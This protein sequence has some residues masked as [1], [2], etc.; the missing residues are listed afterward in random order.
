LPRRWS[1]I[2]PRFDAA[3]FF[4]ARSASRSTA[5]CRAAARLAQ[6]QMLRSIFAP[7]PLTTKP[8]WIIDCR[9]LAAR[10]AR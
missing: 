8:D 1:L 5:A 2:F 4:P 9:G 10:D 3:P 7:T 6:A